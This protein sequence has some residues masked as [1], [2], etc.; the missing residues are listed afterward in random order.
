MASD[1]PFLGIGIV[2]PILPSIARTMGASHF[3]VELKFMSYL[4]VMWLANLVAGALAVV[5]GLI[6]L[7]GRFGEFAV[8]EPEPTPGD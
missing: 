4:L 3:R 2:D 7:L 1:N 5:V 8:S 6:V